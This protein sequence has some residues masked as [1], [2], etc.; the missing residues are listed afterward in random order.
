MGSGVCF[1]QSNPINFHNHRYLTVE[2]EE[3]LFEWRWKLGDIKEL[4][5]KPVNYVN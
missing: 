5:Y 1:K 2:T 4:Y 3:A